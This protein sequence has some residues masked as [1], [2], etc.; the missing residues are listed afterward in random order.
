[1]RIAI[2]TTDTLHHRYF[3]KRVGQDG[4]EIAEICAVLF[5]EKSYPWGRKARRFFWKGLPNVWSGVTANPYLQPTSLNRRIDAWEQQHF[6]GKDDAT[7]SEEMPVTRVHSVNGDEA[8]NCLK[9]ARPDLIVIYGTG[10]VSEE[11]CK[12]ARFG[13]INAHGG[14]LPEYRGLDTNLWAA[15]DGKPECMCVTWHVAETDFDTGPVYSSRALRKEKD[16]DLVSIRGYAAEVCT[17]L[18]LELL[19]G[20]ATGSL[21]PA[22]QEGEGRYFG[23][24]PYL[25]KLKAQSVIR[26]WVK[27]P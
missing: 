22:R 9:R 1:M 25:L 13:A 6:F 5:E 10:L 4:S 18:F 12:L 19:P 27:I 16:L 8:R 2:L 21:R 23:P 26:A 3:L 24:M 11:V 20:L 17:D 15:L 14:Q 7:L